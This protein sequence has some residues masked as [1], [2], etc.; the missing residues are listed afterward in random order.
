MLHYQPSL[1]TER[2]MFA[3]NSNRTAVS[4]VLWF[5]CGCGG[6][7]VGCVCVGVFQKFTSCSSSCIQR[8]DNMV[9]LP[10]KERVKQESVCCMCFFVL[11]FFFSGLDSMQ[12]CISK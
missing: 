11:F 5:L 9:I 1:L 10:F 8:L 4:S 6:C 12:G 7:G 3:Q 2:A